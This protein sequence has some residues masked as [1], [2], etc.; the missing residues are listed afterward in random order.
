[1]KEHLLVP[2]QHCHHCWLGTLSLTQSVDALDRV[3]RSGETVVKEGGRKQFWTHQFYSEDAIENLVATRSTEEILTEDILPEEPLTPGLCPFPVNVSL[4]GNVFWRHSVSHEGG[5]KA[6]DTLF[7]LGFENMLRHSHK[8][9]L[10]LV[11]DANPSCHPLTASQEVH[12]T[13]LEDFICLFISKDHP[14]GIC[15]RRLEVNGDA[16]KVTE[17]ESGDIPF[18]DLNQKTKGGDIVTGGLAIEPHTG[19]RD[20]YNNNNKPGMSFNIVNEETQSLHRSSS[21]R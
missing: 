15:E 3:G 19:A 11:T 16:A 9:L 18:D 4:R 13:S 10:H 21:S 12:L 5:K 14:E 6:E 1:M 20:I 8:L 17:V 2:I 7:G